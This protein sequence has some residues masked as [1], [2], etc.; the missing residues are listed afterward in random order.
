MYSALKPQ[1][2]IAHWICASA[3]AG[4]CL[5]TSPRG[6]STAFAEPIVEVRV[7]PPAAR[8]EVVPRAPSARH[9][10]V[11]GYWAWNGRAHVWVPGSY[12][13]ERRGYEFHESRWEEAHGHWRFHRGGWHRR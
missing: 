2:C 10:W 3:V 11:H 7:A 12:V 9:F 1:R 8:V 4:V 13:V 5:I 6:I